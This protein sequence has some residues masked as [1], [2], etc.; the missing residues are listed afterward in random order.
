MKRTPTTPWKKPLLS[1]C[2][3]HGITQE[4]LFDGELIAEYAFTNALKM[5]GHVWRK[6]GEL[7]IAAK[8]SPERIPHPL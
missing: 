7:I 8:G 5:M 6:G 3:Q 1:F 2:E 4:S